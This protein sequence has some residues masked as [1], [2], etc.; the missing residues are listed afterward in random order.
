M[1]SATSAEARNGDRIIS[2]ET[3]PILTEGHGDG[4]K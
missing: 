3:L 4:V 1:N 2:T